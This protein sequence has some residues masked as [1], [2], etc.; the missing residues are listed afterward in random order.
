[1]W[2]W[3]RLIPSDNHQISQDILKSVGSAV[4]ADRDSRIGWNGS[5]VF[6]RSHAPRGNSEAPRRGVSISET[7]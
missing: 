2:L 1:M 5:F 7:P 4:R 6:S 3:N